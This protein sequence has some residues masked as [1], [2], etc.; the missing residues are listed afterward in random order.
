MLVD[1]ASASPSTLGFGLLAPQRTYRT[2]GRRNAGP[3]RSSY[4]K[5]PG[6]LSAYYCW[7]LLALDDDPHS[8]LA[9]ASKRPIKALRMAILPVPVRRSVQEGGRI[10]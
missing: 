6:T 5:M 1:A 9:T 4:R 7:Q 10:V 8:T 2:P 3:N